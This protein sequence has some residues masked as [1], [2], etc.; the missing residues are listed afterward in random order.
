MSRARRFTLRVNVGWW[1]D[2]WLPTVLVLSASEAACVFILRRLGRD[3]QLAVLL[4]AIGMTL[5]AVLAY[6]I[7]RRKFYSIRDGLVRLEHQHQL[8]NRLSAAADGV[9]DWPLSQAEADDGLRWH[10]PRFLIPPLLS[11]LLV[12]ASLLIPMHVIQAVSHTPTAEPV[13]WRQVDDWLKTIQEET[14]TEPESL[15][16]IQKQL[17]EL[18]AQPKHKWY[19]HSSLEAGDTLRNQ[20]QHQLREFQRNLESAIALV[21]TMKTSPKNMSNSMKKQWR[22]HMNQT[23]NN[24]QSGE[25][26]LDQEWLDN[27][28]KL[29]F[30]PS[31]FRTLTDEE[32]RALQQALNQGVKACQQCTGKGTNDVLV[33]VQALGGA[34]GSGVAR[35]PGTM[36]LTLKEQETQLGTTGLEVV[37]NKDFSRAALGTTLAVREKEHE[38]DESNDPG[39]VEA[40]EVA[41][42]GEGGETVWKQN[43][44][45][46]ERDVL[47][48]YFK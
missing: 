14:F 17:D 32:M 42:E 37:Q 3:P 10:W 16:K 24:F 46:N 25:L 11:V 1:L 21:S 34:F 7:G 41:S 44:M 18:R 12:V 15:Q 27:L 31:T 45:P 19:R 35:G 4:Y 29:E 8:H 20:T 23:L 2:V 43:L 36:P 28:K 30:D 40:G 6:S 22:K 39:P 33:L 5:A 9:G 13:A 38:I 48:N 26:Q 47:E